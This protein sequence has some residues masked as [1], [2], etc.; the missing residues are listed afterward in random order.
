VFGAFIGDAA[1]AT[2]EFIEHSKINN[3]S[4]EKAMMLKGGGVFSV[5][6]G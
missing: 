2:L 6:P 3:D 5:G 4:V 1:G